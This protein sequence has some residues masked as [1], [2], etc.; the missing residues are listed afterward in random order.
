MLSLRQQ[1]QNITVVEDNYK[2]IIIFNLSLEKQ[3]NIAKLQIDENA[4]DE[5]CCEKKSVMKKFLNKYSIIQ[6]LLF[7]LQGIVSYSLMLV[8]MTFN[9]WL[10][11]SLILGGK[12]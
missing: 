2:L 6:A 1:T 12:L 7:M 8:F 4:D 10:C 5:V 3:N 11:A 9:A